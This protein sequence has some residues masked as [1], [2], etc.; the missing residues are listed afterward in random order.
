MFFAISSPLLVTSFSIG[1]VEVMSFSLFSTRQVNYFLN[2][3]ASYFM[4]KW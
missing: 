3:S 2:S 4:I 1:T